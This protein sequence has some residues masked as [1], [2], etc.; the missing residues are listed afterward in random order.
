MGLI[1]L[2]LYGQKWIPNIYSY[3]SWA[4]AFANMFPLILHLCQKKIFWDR[5][6]ISDRNDSAH[7]QFLRTPL[8]YIPEF[9]GLVV[10]VEQTLLYQILYLEFLSISKWLIDRDP[11]FYHWVGAQCVANSRFE[12][13]FFAEFRVQLDRTPRVTSRNVVFNGLQQYFCGRIHQK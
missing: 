1:F 12:Q 6:V 3:S 4:R 10:F 5:L 7:N 11:L 13:N 2:L 8:S 9:S